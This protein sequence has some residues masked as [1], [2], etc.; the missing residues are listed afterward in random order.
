MATYGVAGQKVRE[1]C[2]Q[3]IE[4]FHPDLAESKARI[5]L[6]QAYPSVDRNG[7]SP[8]PAMVT[9]GCRILA[10]IKINSEE[11]RCAGSPDATLT[12]DAAYWKE[13]DEADD[14]EEG[15]RKQ[16][17]LLDHELYHLI[18]RKKDGEFVLDDQR[19]PK[20]ASRPH[21][22]EV[23]GFR[24]VAERHRQFAPEVI[25]ARQFHD[26][27]GNLLFS[28]A[29]DLASD[30]YREVEASEAVDLEAIAVEQG[31]DGIERI[32][33]PK[34]PSKSRKGRK[35]SKGYKPAVAP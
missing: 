14:P 31:E 1:I 9:K 13:L 33:P 23:T 7:D 11:A 21:D 17:A 30:E 32:V 20:L 3:V 29:E 10:R 19:R 24:V 16:E 28:F 2:D 8:R 18:N 26:D 34:K 35:G 22:W 5:G 27:F 25:I 6:L 12:I 4:R 15:R